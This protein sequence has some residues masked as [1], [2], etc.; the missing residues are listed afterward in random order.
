MIQISMAYTT[1][2]IVAMKKTVTRRH[3]KLRHV[4]RFHH[5]TRAMAWSRQPQYGGER[6]AIIELIMDPYLE[7]IC[8]V[9]P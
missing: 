2:A 4:L 6:I 9:D 3:W 1:P 8:D 7:K 5:G